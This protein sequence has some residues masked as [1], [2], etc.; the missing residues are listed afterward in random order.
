MQ[1]AQSSK[2][3]SGRSGRYMVH[4]CMEGLFI[5]LGFAVLW[6]LLADVSARSLRRQ[7]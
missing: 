2:V 7:P 1:P 4:A 3:G 6:A 5:G